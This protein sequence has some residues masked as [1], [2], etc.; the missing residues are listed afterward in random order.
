DE[1]SIH[2]IKR[3]PS[4]QILCLASDGLWDYLANE[5]VAD[6][7]LNSLSLGHDCNMIAARLSHCVQALGGADDLSIM[8]VNLKEAQLE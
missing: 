3:D 5:E 4:Q 6:M 2:H 8:V 7:I 1:P